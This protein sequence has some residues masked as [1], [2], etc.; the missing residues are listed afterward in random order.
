MWVFLYINLLLTYIATLKINL[1][2]RESLE[3]WLY[4]MMIFLEFAYFLMSKLIVIVCHGTGSDF[5]ASLLNLAVNVYYIF[6]FL[7]CLPR[8]VVCTICYYA[9]ATTTL[10]AY[11]RGSFIWLDT[12]INSFSFFILM[13][14]KVCQ[15]VMTNLDF[16]FSWYFILDTKVL[17]LKL[18][19]GNKI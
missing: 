7:S 6:S 17:G 12:F 8:F 16:V 4:F 9:T 11:L 14:I 15:W 18:I 5:S 2:S 3:W 19:I 10:L 1:S 13:Q